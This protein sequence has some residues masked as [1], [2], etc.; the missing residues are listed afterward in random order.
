MNISGRQCIVD[1]NAAFK[2]KESALVKL[3]CLAGRGYIEK[4]LNDINDVEKNEGPA[5]E[6]KVSSLYGPK[7]MIMNK[8]LRPPKTFL[9]I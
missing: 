1:P 9:R 8:R 2:F 6:T 5:H 7:D 4:E 3:Q